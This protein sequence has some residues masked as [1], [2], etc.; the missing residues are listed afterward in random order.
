MNIGKLMGIL[1]LALGLVWIAGC[2]A[3]GQ[4][5]R[6]GGNPGA[7][8]ETVS[9][10]G[11]LVDTTI[12]GNPPALVNL[13]GATFSFG[14]TKAKCSF[15]CS[16]DN[17][18]F[19]KCVS[20]KVYAG[21]SEGTH[22]FIVKA[23][24]LNTLKTDKTPA[25]YSWKIDLTPPDTI[26]AFGPF[27]PSTS[28][29]A[30]FWFLASEVSCTFE[31]NLDAG[32]W[33]S[34]TS[35]KSYTSLGQGSH[36]F[37]V[38]ATDLATNQDS[39]PAGYTWT[40]DSVPPDTSIITKP[41]NLTNSNSASFTFSCTGSCSSYEC[42]LD[43]GGFSSCVSG[44]TYSSLSEGD[45]NF[46]VRAQD[47]AGNYDLSPALYNWTRDATAPDTSIIDM[48]SN[49]SASTSASF[50]F[51]ASEFGST[52]QC[53]LDAGGWSTCTS[54]KSYTS[55][56][57]G[58]HTFQVRAA[59]LA[60]NQDSTPASYTWTIDS[61]PPD[62]TISTYPT[63]PTQSN[64]AS[65]TFTCTGACASYECQL[66]FGGFSSCVSGVTY[67]SL[68]E[69]AHNF[70]VRAKD[71][72]GNVDP[73]PAVYN[74]TRDATAPD[75]VITD[76]P[77][78]PSS[79]TG[80]TFTFVCVNDLGCTFE[81]NLDSAGFSVC[82]SPKTYSNLIGGSHNVQV[83]AKDSANNVDSTP[84]S[85]AWSIANAWLA[86]STTGAPSARAY[87]AAVWTGSQMIIWGG[88]TYTSAYLNTGAKYWP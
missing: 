41:A 4:D 18:K 49:P 62:T 73:T 20:P 25:T 8:A 66:D 5:N 7:P 12:L 32:G 50:W 28:A 35:P 29:N 22:K 1:G 82:S 65:F 84:A 46:Q 72:A 68:S 33:S 26:L 19:A 83:R 59:D 69:G 30:T 51:I 54:P 36:T 27:D 14:C 44:V 42:Q 13:D 23:K 67:S 52:F 2:S 10:A 58:S 86:T 48:P 9:Y 57:Q 3:P 39:T 61:L 40:L 38:R 81:C 24:D 60:T 16:L 55:L 74:W 79:S 47:A 70:Q 88:C 31:C 64:S 75:T 15:T 6:S 53:N 43:F 37:Q 45:H 21:L 17:G 56:G 78:N 11:A 34:C 76:Q 71:A 85:Y 63:N 77:E 80:A 87:H